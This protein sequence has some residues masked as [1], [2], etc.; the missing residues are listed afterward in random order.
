MRCSN[1]ASGKCSPSKRCSNSSSGQMANDSTEHRNASRQQKG[2]GREAAMGSELASG[3][4]AES[5]VCVDVDGGVFGACKHGGNLRL[6]LCRSVGTLAA[7]LCED[8]HPQRLPKHDE[9]LK[10]RQLLA[11]EC[12]G[13]EGKPLG[14][15]R[16]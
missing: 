8:L 16:R 15:Q 1:S 10:D 4:V 9:V 2:V 7:L 13:Q 11:G 3:R 5:K 12:A 14:T 6:P